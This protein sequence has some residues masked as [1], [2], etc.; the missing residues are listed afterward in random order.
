M[1]SFWFVVLIVFLA[2]QGKSQTV[3]GSQVDY[4]QIDSFQYQVRFQVCSDCTDSTFQ[5]DSQSYVQVSGDSMTIR[6]S[7]S[8]VKVSDV[9]NYH[10]TISHCGAGDSLFGVLQYTYQDTIDFNTSFISLKSDSAIRFEF[11]TNK[12]LI[13]NTVM[14]GTSDT[15]RTSYN[16]AELLLQEN[17]LGTYFRSDPQFFTGQN[18]MAKSNFLAAINNGVDS[19]SYGWGKS[20]N[21]SA[22]V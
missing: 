4:K 21:D 1:R 5:L 17:V 6:L 15:L 18:Q 9:S 2:V 7:P 20:Y 11:V 3:L 14:C 8:L 19:V 12:M 16:Y 22:L 13:G 10:D